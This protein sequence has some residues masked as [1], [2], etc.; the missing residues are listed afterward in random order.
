MGD[1][2]RADLA[3]MISLDMVAYGN[4]FCQRTMGEG[5]QALRTL[6]KTY[7]A[8]AGVK[9]A[10]ERDPAA[11]GWSDHEPFERA[12]FPAVWLEWRLDQTHH[13]DADTVKHMNPKRLQATGDFVLAFLRDLQ[14]DDLERLATART[15]P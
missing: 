8:D 15:T 7:A 2:E 13:T 11:A 14:D 9:N 6:I 12:G 10:Y 1:Q 4:T 5:P 3:G